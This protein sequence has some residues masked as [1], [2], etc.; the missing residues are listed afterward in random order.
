MEILKME[1]LTIRQAFDAM[2][3]FL[4]DYYE[5]GHSDDIAVLLSG[6]NV[7]LWTDDSTADPA[8]WGDWMKSIQKIVMPETPENRQ[9][10]ENLVT[11][12]ANYLG[13]DS[14]GNECYAQILSDGRQLWAEVRDGKVQ[15]GGVR[16][17]PRAFDPRTGLS[18][19]NSP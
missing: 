3:L 15:Y 10:L 1:T 8:M 17:T 2:F 13:T 18:S 12:P 6:L 19:P 4:E 5:R 7:H 11:D 16:T 14:Y 9:L